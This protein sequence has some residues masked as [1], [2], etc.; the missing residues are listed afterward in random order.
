MR[1]VSSELRLLVMRNI[2]FPSGDRDI[3]EYLPEELDL[4]IVEF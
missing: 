4:R 1:A 2:A 3:T